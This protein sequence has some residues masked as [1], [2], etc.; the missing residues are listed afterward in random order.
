MKTLGT[1]R[2]LSEA[3]QQKGFMNRLKAKK[4]KSSMIVFGNRG[5]GRV[6]KFFLRSISDR[7]ADEPPCPVLIV[8]RLFAFLFLVSE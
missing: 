8:N 7:V 4:D 2:D 1:H 5:L 6:K 3:F